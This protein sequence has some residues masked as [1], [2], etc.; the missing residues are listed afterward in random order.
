MEGTTQG[1]SLISN[2][3]PPPPFFL[4]LIFFFQIMNPA[5]HRS[6]PVQR[7]GKIV[8]KFFKLVNEDGEDT[9][10][11]DNMRALTLDILGQT[12]F[13]KSRF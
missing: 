8:P 13:G 6:M 5:F 2:R 12:A 11:A 3:D 7:F 10:I 1:K 4:T 9:P